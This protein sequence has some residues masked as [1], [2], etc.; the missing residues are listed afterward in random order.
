M[1]KKPKIKKL[2]KME[3]MLRNKQKKE[4]MYKGFGIYVFQNNTSAD[5]M[6]PKPTLGNQKIIPKNGIF[7]GDSFFMSMVKN[8]ALKLIE[9]IQSEEEFLKN[10]NENIDK[11]GEDMQNKLILD[12]P[13]M[14]TTQGTVEHVQVGNCSVKQNENLNL[15]EEEKNK[16]VLLVE[17]PIGSIEI[18]NG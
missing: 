5:L 6:L 8:N 4:N 18:I 15:T 10:K 3:K 1:H 2:T 7:R 17:D 9:V 12:Q 11:T 13:A 14:V 16:D